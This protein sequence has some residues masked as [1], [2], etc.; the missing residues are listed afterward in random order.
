MYGFFQLRR[1]RYLVCIA[2]GGIL[3]GCAANRELQNYQLSSNGEASV[4]LPIIEGT[5]VRRGRVCA[6]VF[7]VDEQEVGDRADCT[8]AIPILPGEHTIAAWV[9]GRAYLY[10]RQPVFKLAT[11]TLNFH[12]KEGHRYIISLARVG[13]SFSQLRALVWI[14]D[15]TT[16]TPAT[17]AK[18]VTSRLPNT[19][20]HID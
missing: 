10:H 13:Y 15:E 9:E 14:N 8:A 12:A 16:Q 3:G 2:I 4:Q 5:L 18:L 1:T 6:Y 17:E 7:S 19:V 20:S 11:A